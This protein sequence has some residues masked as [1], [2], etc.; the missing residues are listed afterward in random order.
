MQ[1]FVLDALA[2]LTA[3]V[4]NEDRMSSEDVHSTA[5]TAA[6][7]IGNANV[8]ISRMRRE[9]VIYFVNKFLIPLT[10]QEESFSKAP[11]GLFG[12]G[13]AHKSKVF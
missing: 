1:T 11:P 10:K 4:V 8:R 6:E 2:H 5:L 3:I 9:K 12:S 13:F 7:L